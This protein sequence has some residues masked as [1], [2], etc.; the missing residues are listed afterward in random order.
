MG[1]KGAKKT[2]SAT[3]SKKDLDFLIKQ[4]GLPKENIQAVFTKFSANNPDHV[5]DRKEFVRLYD[6]LRPES[7]DVLDEISVYIFDA[8]DKDNNGTIS[9]NEFLI[10]YALTSRG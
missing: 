10:A 1:N 9:F 5:L 3:L 7:A 8:F 4:T 2:A 6:E